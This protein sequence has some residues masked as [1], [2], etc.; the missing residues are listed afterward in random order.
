MVKLMFLLR[1]LP[2]FRDKSAEKTHQRLETKFKERNAS[3]KHMARLKNK[4]QERGDK[5]QERGK[6]KVKMAV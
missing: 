4:G 2:N 1:L 6:K 5:S 3:A